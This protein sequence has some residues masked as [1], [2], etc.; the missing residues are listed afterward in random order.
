MIFNLIYIFET[1]NDLLYILYILININKAIPF[2][3]L[4]N[5]SK[6]INEFTVKNSFPLHAFTQF[7]QY[8][9]LHSF[10]PL[11]I[12]GSMKDY[13]LGSYRSPFPQISHTKLIISS[14]LQQTMIFL[15]I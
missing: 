6:E 8:S 13:L 3:L 4:I 10:S 1:G 14:E 12:F 7:L 11:K 15:K 2:E 9:C 5:F